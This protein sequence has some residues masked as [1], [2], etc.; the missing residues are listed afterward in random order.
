MQQATL[1]PGLA[2][3]ISLASLA[4]V[5]LVACHN[6]NQ[7][8][9]PAFA[10]SESAWRKQRQE[11]LTR[12]DGWLTLVGLHW[13]KPGENPVGSEPSNTVVLPEAPGVQPHAGVFVLGEDG[14]VRIRCAPG[15][16]V[17]LE[18]KPVG[19]RTLRTDADPGGPDI[20]HAGRILF[21]AIRRSDRTGVRVKDPE[22]PTRTGFKGLSW[23]PPDTKWVITGNLERFAEP[24]EIEI[25]TAIGT[26]EHML[27]P[28]VINFTIDGAEL[29][30]TPMISSPGDTELFIVFADATSGPETYGAG[31]FL[32]AKAADNGTVTLDFN[33][34]YN[35]PC[36][37]TPH[38]TCPLPPPENVLPIPI[39]AGEKIYDRH[40]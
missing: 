32:D 38:A 26:T 3:K 33:R 10:A 14:T 29:R 30:L 31:R 34:A 27:A 22:S 18:G 11:R 19:E 9:D 28:G 7:A 6:S 4:L 24:H 21:Y 1:L 25:S 8:V 5:A 17:Q 15:S 36:A 20:L 2:L 16:G 23:Y 37:F 35:P 40:H 13:L 39:R 12:P